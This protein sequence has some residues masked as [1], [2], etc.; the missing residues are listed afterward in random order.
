MRLDMILPGSSTDLSEAIREAEE[1]RRAQ[2]EERERKR[3]DSFD[4]L[5]TEIEKEVGVK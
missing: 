4:R 1:Q 2:Q 3:I 5:M